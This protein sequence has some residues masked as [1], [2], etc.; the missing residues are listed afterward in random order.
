LGVNPA[1]MFAILAKSANGWSQ[2]L[3]APSRLRREWGQL[4]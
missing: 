2:Q 1:Y 4:S 3:V